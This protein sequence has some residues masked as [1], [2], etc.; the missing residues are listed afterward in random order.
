MLEGSVSINGRELETMVSFRS[1]TADVDSE[2]FGKPVST[3]SINTY[4]K[5]S[6]SYSNLSEKS[7]YSPL[8]EPRHQRDLAALKLQKVHKSFRTRSQLADCA[9]MVS[10]NKFTWLNQQLDLSKN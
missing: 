7:Y 10:F 3:M 4:D 5:L 6:R 2:L 8:L 1:P 9:E